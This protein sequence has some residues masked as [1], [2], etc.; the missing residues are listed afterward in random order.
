MNRP[1]S[2]TMVYWRFKASAPCPW[3]FGYVT[4]LENGDM[5]RLGAWNGDATNGRVVD[6]SEIEWRPYSRG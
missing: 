1:P 4:Y 2:G 6:A 3:V 5:I